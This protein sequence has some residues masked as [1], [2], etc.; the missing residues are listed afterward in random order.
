MVMCQI[1]G[2]FKFERRL[3]V[4]EN[5]TKNFFN[6]SFFIV[7]L[8]FKVGRDCLCFWNRWG[9]L[10][11]HVL[12]TC[13]FQRAYHIKKSVILKRYIHFLLTFFGCF[14]HNFSSSSCNSF[15]SSPS[16]TPSWFLLDFLK[17][18]L[19]CALKQDLVKFM[20]V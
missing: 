13:T 8:V 9:L 16:R 5:Y 15:Q 6:F 1:R 7:F 10:I 2:R 18:R 3:S 11:L 12:K 20:V 14:Q 17:R 19:F 4:K